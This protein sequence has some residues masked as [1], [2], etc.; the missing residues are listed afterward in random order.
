MLTSEPENAR[1]WLGGTLRD[2][3]VTACGKWSFDEGRTRP[4]ELFKWLHQR[5]WK[6]H[7][8]AKEAA[9][10]GFPSLG[11]SRLGRLGTPFIA[12]QSAA[13]EMHSWGKNMLRFSP[14]AGRSARGLLGLCSV[15]HAI[16]YLGKAAGHVGMTVLFH[17]LLFTGIGNAA[18]FLVFG[19]SRLQKLL[20]LFLRQGVEAGSGCF[21]GLGD[22]SPSSADREDWPPRRQVFEQLGGM[23]TGFFGITPR[24]QQ[25]NLRLALV[26]H[27]IRT[28]GGTVECN[29][30][31]ELKFIDQSRQPGF[32]AAVKP[33]PQ[34]ARGKNSVFE[35]VAQDLKQDRGITLPGIEFAGI[36]N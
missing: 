8:Q 30:V 11:W 5:P 13:A 33:Y 14:N 6:R 28:R 26:R 12:M 22:Y 25:Q 19:I 3:C 36:S 1:E 31:I 32:D 21:Q 23:V 10:A 24:Q 2:N 35:K 7:C 29:H 17:R 16:Q 18:F 20:H 4:G 9:N 27:G 34:I 15:D